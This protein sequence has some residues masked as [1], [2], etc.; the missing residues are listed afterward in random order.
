[1]IS[2]FSRLARW[3]ARELRRLQDR[4]LATYLREDLVPFS[5]YYSRLFAERG[6]DVE[7]IESV[8]DL[9]RLPFTTKEDLVRELEV[10][11]LS[12]VLQPTAEKIRASWP[13]ARLLPLAVRRVL[14]GEADV[15]RVLSKEYRPIFMTATTGRSAHPVSFLYSKVDLRRLAAAGRRLA[16][17]L[18]LTMEDR[19]LNLFPYAPHL[20][21]WQTAFAGFESRI[22]VLSTGGGKTIGTVGNVRAL[23]R[24]KPTCIIG[25]PSYVYHILRT[26]EA[27]GEQ[28]PWLKV[29]V[30]GAEKVTDGLKR[31]VA[32]LCERV[33]APGVSVQ[34]TYGF[35]EAKMAWGEVSSGGYMLYPDMEIFEIINPDTGEVLPEGASG[36]IV[37]TALGARGTA[38]LRYRT[39]D[40]CE[41]G[42]TWAPCPVTGRTLPRL[43]SRI[44]RLSNCTDYRLT[45]VK[46]TLIDL[47]HIV[48][49][50][51]DRREVE[52]WQLEIRKQHDDPAEVDIMTLY[53]AAAPGMTIDPAA[54]SRMIFDATE[55][56]LNA[57]IIEDVPTLVARI[58][59]ETEMK[60]KRIV[61]HRPED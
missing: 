55:V 52:E 51:G 50:L 40:F 12:F 57:V 29:V 17:V 47:N 26:A 25:V 44:T 28:L 3:P 9:A 20:A 46:G 2:N 36:E 38:I 15:R 30:L 21:F 33:G 11:P 24:M 5:P 61:D 10:D 13:M 60:E 49:L 48:T 6:I 35:T 41:G 19:I 59:L 31:R 53:A 58:G 22:F 18:G 43:S 32:E 16:V 1:M 4:M 23:S 37:Y 27:E 42:I 56:S 14:K 8:A 7:D 45:K 34:G 54:L 39:G